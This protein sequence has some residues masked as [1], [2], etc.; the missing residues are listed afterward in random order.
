[1][2]VNW[3]QGEV[4]KIK[5]CTRRHWR[6]TTLCRYNPVL[7]R[8]LSRTSSNFFKCH[9]GPYEGWLCMHQHEGLRHL[10]SVQIKER[11]FHACLE[12]MFSKSTQYCV[13]GVPSRD[14]NNQVCWAHAVLVQWVADLQECKLLLSTPAQVSDLSQSSLCSVQPGLEK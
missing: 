5:L 1:M 11:Y 8:I 14:N 10:T 4:V 6:K 9:T 7:V 13:Q 3:Y 12:Q 2:I